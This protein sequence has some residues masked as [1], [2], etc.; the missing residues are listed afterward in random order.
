MPVFAFQPFKSFL[1]ALH[2][3]LCHVSPDNEPSNQMI[4]QFE[5]CAP[6]IVLLK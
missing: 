3:L 6:H 2:V 4:S 5:F 1:L